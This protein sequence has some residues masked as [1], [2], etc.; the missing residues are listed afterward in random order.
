MLTLSIG[1]GMFWAL[2]D[3]GYNVGMNW[4]R[5]ESSALRLTNHRDYESAVEW[6]EPVSKGWVDGELR[7]LPGL[8]RRRKDE[9]KWYEG[10][11]CLS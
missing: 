8:L 5:T 7:T 2:C 4:L 9:R 1:E 3:L 10:D 11:L 6:F